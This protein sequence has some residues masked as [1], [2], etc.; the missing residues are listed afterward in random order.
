MADAGEPN[1]PAPFPSSGRFAAPPGLPLRFAPRAERVEGEGLRR[2]EKPPSAAER[3][4]A[5]ERGAPAR[6]WR[7]LLVED[8]RADS[9]LVTRLLEEAE[10]PCHVTTVRDAEAASAALARESGPERPDAVLLD[11]NLPGRSGFELLGEI[12]ESP[13]LRDLPVFLLTTSRSAEDAARGKALGATDFLSKPVHLEDFEALLRRF[14]TELLPAAVAEAQRGAGPAPAAS[15][16]VSGESFRLLVQ[17]VRD[18]AIFM[19][20]PKG[21]IVTWNEGAERIKGYRASEILGR[22]FSVFYDQEAIDRRHPWH[23]LEVATAVGRFEEEGWRLRKDGVRFWAHV[24]ITALRDAHGALVGFGKVTRDVTARRQAEEALRASEERFRLL[25]Q[26]VED[27]ALFMLDPEGIVVSWNLGAERIN[28]YKAAEVLGKHFSIFYT[29]EAI[30]TRHPEEELRIAREEGVYEEEGIRVRKD[31]SLFWSNVVITALRDAGGNLR[32][33]SKVTRDITERKQVEEER[34][35]ILRE[36]EHRV[37]LRTAELEESKRALEAKAEELVRSNADLQQFAYIASHDLQEPL[38]AVVTYLQLLE[39][40]TGEALDEES[41]QYVKFAVDGALWMRN[42]VSDLLSYAAI[43][44]RARELT[45]VELG[46]AVETAIANVRASIDETAAEIEIGTLPEVVGDPT[47][48]VRLFQNLIGNAIKYRSTE[49]PRI[50]ISAEEAPTEWTISVA[51]NGIGIAPQHRER[52]FVVF[53]RLHVD[54]DRYPGTGIGLALCRRIVERNGGK[55]WVESH[56]G[57]G[58]TFRFT[59]PKRKG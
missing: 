31:G 10:V 26:G 27:Y 24:T 30:E 54:R 33:Y 21:Y 17:G 48:I 56:L 8:S 2:E 44:S 13:L 28:G 38:R 47:E 18:Y 53:Q 59:L 46:P 14:L 52:I 36:V 40:R 9:L 7:I 16:E 4:T 37:A 51:D 29:K 35:R 39:R 11:L 41:Q 45:R 1:A 23:E 19:L 43:G 22:H 20:D 50:R 12:R 58:S 57:A 42:L 34:A 6:P 3:K 55:I 5:G 32:G 25:V 49:P 15:T